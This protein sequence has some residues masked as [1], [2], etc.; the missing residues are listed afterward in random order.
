[1][2]HY[3]YNKTSEVLMKWNMDSLLNKTGTTPIPDVVNDILSLDKFIKMKTGDEV[4]V[5]Q[6]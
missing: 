1:M 3:Q 4:Q 6:R 2:L 5:S